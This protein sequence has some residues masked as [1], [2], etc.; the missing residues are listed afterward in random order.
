MQVS[1]RFT[2]TLGT[3]STAVGIGAALDQT[4]AGTNMN[5]FSFDFGFLLIAAIAAVGFSIL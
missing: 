2:V 4:I 3:I 1:G 5:H